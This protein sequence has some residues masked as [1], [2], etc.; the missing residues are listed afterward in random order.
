MA[1]ANSQA[2][3][4]DK[5]NAALLTQVAAGDKD[6]FST[7]FRHFYE[8]LTRFAY[9]YLQSPE[10]IEEV[11]NDTMLMVWQNAGDFR[12]ESRVS[13]WIMSIVARKCWKA[14][15]QQQTR[16][17]KE[18]EVEQ[19]DAQENPTGLLDD[20][21][22]MRWGIEQ[23]SEDHRACVEL[24]YGYGYTCEE[25]AGI[26][27]CPVNTVKTRLHHARK[28]LKTIFERHEQENGGERNGGYHE[29]HLK[30]ATGP[31]ALRGA[32]ARLC[33]RPLE[34]QRTTRIAGTYSP[35][36]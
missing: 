32:D 16:Q 17:Q 18:S 28:S 25:I 23:L 22:L 29:S 11:V 26:M 33:E 30:T 10:M 15:R 8:P 6:A 21:S 24:A 12:G 27:E 4:E 14:A 34:Q 20:Q 19:D 9:R 2:Q 3:A 35:V 5:R 13:T 7:L 31:R 36:R 1:G